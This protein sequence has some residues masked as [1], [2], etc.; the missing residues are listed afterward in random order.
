MVIKIAGALA[1]NLRGPGRLLNAAQ[2]P[3]WTPDNDGPQYPQCLWETLP[4]CIQ[5]LPGKT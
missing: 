1:S 3:G 5:K 2:C 4:S